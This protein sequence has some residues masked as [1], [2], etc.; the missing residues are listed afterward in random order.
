MAH[1]NNVR[2]NPAP[3]RPQVVQHGQYGPS[4]SNLSRSEKQTGMSS[5]SR[6]AQQ[7]QGIPDDGGKRAESASSRQH[8]STRQDQHRK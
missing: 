1:Q 7:N 2:G 3:L 4:N 5:G 8:Q 6:Q